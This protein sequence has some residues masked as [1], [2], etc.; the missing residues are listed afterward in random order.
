MKKFLPIFSL[1]LISVSLEIQA[2]DTLQISLQQFLDKAIAN[3]GQ[4]KHANTK[5]NLAENRVKEAKDQ[6][7]LP[8][9][10]FRSEHAAVP[11]VSSPNDFPEK[12]IYLDPDAK[13]DWSKIGVYTRLRISGVQP[14]F[15][16]GSVNKAV[17]A[18]EL[19]VKASEFEKD[20]TEAE[21]TARLFELYYSYVLALEIERLLDDANSKVRQIERSLDD[22]TSES[23]SDVDETD[24]YK[25][26]IF[27]SQFEIQKAEVEQNLLFVKG[28]W[29]YV[30]RGED[31]VTYEPSVRYLEKEA[32][33]LQTLDHYKASAFNNRPEIR[34]LEA[35]IKALDRYIDFQ[36]AQNLPGLYFGFT[37]TFAST[38]IRPRQPNP[39]ISTPENTF[40]TALGF[41]IRQNLNLF[42]VKNKIERSK[43]EMKRTTLLK[44]AAQDGIMLEVSEAYKDANLADVKVQRTEEALNTSKEWVRMEQLDYDFGIGEVK[45]LIDAMKMELEL[46]LKEKEYI[47]ELNTSMVKL[48][49]AA[50]LPLVQPQNN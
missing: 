3:S 2:Q 32:V 6:K 39:F 24:V 43:L 23:D 48:N 10:E 31:N 30:L 41:S 11:G 17:H 34:G 25:F 35:G 9:L 49:K 36:K 12:Q 47:F 13:N 20:V 14:V 40:N 46:R 8:S 15:T 16:W 27:K 37:T 45:D 50:G 44:T 18:A 42:Q 21:L 22:A 29:D 7:Y 5:V 26:K 28:V 1:L 33:A 4:I 19:A 38:P